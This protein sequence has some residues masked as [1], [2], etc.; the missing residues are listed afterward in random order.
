MMT[1]STPIVEQTITDVALLDKLAADRN[2][3][4]NDRHHAGE[5]QQFLAN[6]LLGK[7]RAAEADEMWLRAIRSFEA[8]NERFMIPFALSGYRQYLT[9]Q[10]GQLVKSSRADEAEALYRHAIDAIDKM[11]AE[12]PKNNEL[13]QA[14]QADTLGHLASTLNQSGHAQDA[15]VAATGSV[16]IYQKLLRDHPKE[17]YRR[18]MA[19]AG[20]RLSRLLEGAGK[21]VEAE[22][23]LR[24]LISAAP[25]QLGIY[26]GLADLLVKLDRIEEATAVIQSAGEQDLTDALAINDLAWFLTTTDTPQLRDPNLAVKLAQ[27]AVDLEPKSAQYLNTLGTAQYRGGKWPESI[28]SL[29]KAEELAPG[30]TLAYNGFFL[31]MAHWQ[32]GHQDEARKWHQQSVEWMTTNQPTNKELVRF[33]AEAEELLGVTEPGPP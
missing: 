6:F 28:A 12:H 21:L 11:A 30:Q 15:A 10:V 17:E 24:T 25:T 13:Y 4:V 9:Q 1:W 31:A 5:T 7:N 19:R 16:D 2:A 32:L 8:M 18:G 27:K 20:V 26:Q 23:Q 3:T 14:F 29:A 22:A 33:R